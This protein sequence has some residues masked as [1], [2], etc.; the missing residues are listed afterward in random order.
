MDRKSQISERLTHIKSE[1]SPEVHL[2]VVTKTFPLSDVEI[3][4]QLGQREFG[5][6]RDQEA[7]G[8]AEQVRSDAIWHFQGRIQSNKLKSILSWCDYIHSLDD[9]NHAQKISEIALQIGKRQKCFLQINLDEEEAINNS[10]SGISSKEFDGFISHVE[11]LSGLELV[12]VMGVGPLGKDPAPAFAHLATLSQRLQKQHP[13]AKFISAGMS[14]DYKVA[15]QH[16][17][18]HIRLGSS[19]LGTR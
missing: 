3:L 2:I 19:I 5:E 14:G 12:G 16:G 17:A 11:P 10:R 4:Y 15:L 18:T 6:N 7:V 1:L 8:K 13:N 9:I